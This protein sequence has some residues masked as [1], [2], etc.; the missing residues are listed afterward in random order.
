MRRLLDRPLARRREPA[1]LLLD[2]LA[3]VDRD[4]GCRQPTRSGS[5]GY[6]RRRK[7]AAAERSAVND[8]T[9]SRVPRIGRPSGWSSQKPCVKS[10][11][12]QIVGRVL[13]HLD[14]F[15]DD[16]LL[17]LDV[18]GGERRIADDV[19]E[20][21]DGERQVLVEDLDVVAR[22]FLGGERVELPADAN[23]S[24]CAM[25]SALR[26][27]VPLKSM[28]STKCAMPPRSAVSCR[29]PAR[30]PDADADRTDLRH[31]LGENAKA[32]I[33]SCLSTIAEFDKGGCSQQE[34]RFAFVSRAGSI[35]RKA[36][37]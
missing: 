26:V 29:E 17:A 15:D 33:E 27:S 18:F 21:V 1:E 9:V 2:K 37:S 12:T 23:R 34:L 14:L 13:D 4:R 16:L 5:R 7:V 6:A 10:S 32:V 35:C 8:S 20:D 3:H 31:R 22:V 30:Q 11:C 36:L 24:A 25:S 19:G 28:C